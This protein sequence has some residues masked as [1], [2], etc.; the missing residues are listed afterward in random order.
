MIHLEEFKKR[1]LRLR[2]L[3]RVCLRRR[4]PATPLEHGGDDKNAKSTAIKNR[5]KPNGVLKYATPLP[6]PS[7]IPPSEGVA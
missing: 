1:E 6:T 7:R 2:Q 4:T 3:K 5:Y